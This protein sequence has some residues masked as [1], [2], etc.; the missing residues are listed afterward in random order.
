MR[1]SGMSR[2]STILTR[3]DFIEFIYRGSSSHRLPNVIDMGQCRPTAT[4]LCEAA[5]RP[6]PRYGLMLY[7]DG[8][9]N[10]A[11]H[12]FVAKYERRM[13]GGLNL[14]F[15]YAFAKALSDAW[16]ASNASSNQIATCRSCSRGPTNFDVRSRAVVS[17]VWEVPF[18][19]LSGWRQLA[20]AGWSL[21][22]IGVFSTGQPV[23]LRGPNQTGSPFITP[24][25]NRVCDGRSDALAD[26][27]RNNGFLWFEAACFPVPA[28]GY[29]GNSGPTVLPGPGIHNWDL[30]VQKSFPLA[31]E[32][33]RLQFRAEMFNAW[34]HAQFQQPN[35]DAGAG[36]NFGR[37]SA[38][39]APRLVQL[40]LKLLW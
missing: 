3:N 13:D 17:A 37:I 20:T 36:G 34:N 23:N 40:A 38:S 35:G 1:A 16:Q 18:Q 19:H 5:T 32:T 9:G 21:T 7:Q 2:S 25:P 30:G 8:A 14:R 39:R 4:L 29:F 6:W 11:Y 27:V 28:V 10:A 31:R 15:E 33:A 26:N 24:L 22:A 12:A